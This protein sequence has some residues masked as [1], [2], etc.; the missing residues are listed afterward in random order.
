[1]IV[2]VDVGGTFSDFVILEK[3]KIIAYKR[4]NPKDVAEGIKK[5]IKSVDE[6]H[7]GSTVGI[8]ALLERKG[9]KITLITTKGFGTLYRIGRQSRRN[10]YSLLP[11]RERL[12]VETV[13]EVE[14]RTLPDGKV[15]KEVDD[16][17]LIEKLSSVK[18]VSAAIVFLHSYINPHNEIR[19]K[20]VARKFCKYV[21]A[22]HEVRREIREYE[23]TTTT[24]VESYVYP[25]V[26]EYLSSLRNISENFY[27]MQSSGGKIMPEYLKGVN[28]L[29]SG[30]SGGV[31]AARYISQLLGFKN[32]ITY[33]MGGT[34]AD[35]GIIVNGEPLYRSQIE[36][37]GIPIRVN[38]VDIV[39]IGAGGGSIAWI[40][41]GNVLKVGP[42]SAGANPGPAC[43][44]RGGK[45]ATVTDANLLLGVLGDEMS[46]IRLKRELAKKA[47]K[48]L[49]DKLGLST[50]D[51][52]RGIIN[53]V[54]NNMALAMKK[55]SLERGYDP[56]VFV[57]FAFG[58]AGP[59]HAI[60]LAEEV[61]IEKIFVPSMAGAFS[62]L[63][64][65]LSPLIYD[66]TVTVMKR[67]DEFGEV[68]D[69][70]LQ[71]FK[72]RADKI[73]KNYELS[74]IMDMRYHGQGH[75]IKV[76]LCEN[77]KREF[78]NRHL[79]LY[80]FTM[81]EE[82]IVVNV[83]LIA[84]RTMEI[85]IPKIKMGQQKIK[86]KR[87]YN[88][89]KDV[90]IY[91]INHFRACEGPCIIEESTTTILVKDGWHASLGEYGVMMEASR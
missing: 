68:L 90:P 31:A 52:A 60:Y 17:E 28:T 81:D 41:E 2:S 40:D 87:L 65:L 59:M 16:R 63:G 9:K 75:E 43:Y 69:G 54:N 85:N 53:I 6:F 26:N 12:P 19:A 20:E 32:V 49:A 80:G 27:V 3:G 30:P 72:R 88:F 7:H 23:R 82:I 33:D 10:V 13:I 66:H 58:G 21:F 35:M 18:C 36:V 29:M 73:L 62:S 57:L 78:E 83:N 25:V 48:S 56:R 1:M 22:S 77:I 47:V 55:I 38:S 76:P 45:D 51:I 11:L 70:I 46:G 24:I 14:E 44:G 37:D 74:V 34:S 89:E 8:N 4:I 64:I 39:S 79:A 5:E 61:G 71:E 91:H 15:E 67:V 50:E 86:G 84:K 42:V